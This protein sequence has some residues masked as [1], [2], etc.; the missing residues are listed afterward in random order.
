MA[1]S[2]A[3]VYMRKTVERYIESMEAN[4][5]YLPRLIDSLGKIGKFNAD[6]RTADI[7]N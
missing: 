7:T 3:N 6:L 5:Q 1:V 2:E 4:L